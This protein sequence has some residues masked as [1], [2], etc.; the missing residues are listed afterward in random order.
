MAPEAFCA[1]PDVLNTPGSD[2][3]SKTLHRESES[4]GAA[5]AGTTRSL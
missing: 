4:D 5:C 2:T 3:T 1:R